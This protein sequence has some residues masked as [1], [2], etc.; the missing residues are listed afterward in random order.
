MYLMNRD[1]FSLLVMGFT[2]KDA[3]AWK[4]QYIKAFNQM[5]K[6]IRE[7]GTAAYRI[8]DQEERMTRRTETDAI[9]EFVEYA[10]AQGCVRQI[11]ITATVPGLHI[12]L[13]GSQIRE[14]RPDLSWMICPWWSI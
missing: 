2:G 5:E 10:R 6:L 3:L 12:R 8:S 14:L 4:L 7:K 1:G 13:W 11:I 9:K